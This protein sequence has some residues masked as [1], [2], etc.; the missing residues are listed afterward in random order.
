[1]LD[2]FE[3]FDSEFREFSERVFNEQHADSA[4]RKN[5]QGGAFCSTIIPKRLH[6][7]C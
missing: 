4:I 5:K 1:M 2:T 7:S 3:E 6:T